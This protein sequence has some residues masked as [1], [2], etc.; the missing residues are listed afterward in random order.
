MPSHTDKAY[1]FLYA[2]EEGRWRDIVASFSAGD[3]DWEDVQEAGVSRTQST[4]I[5]PSVM[6]F[7]SYKECATF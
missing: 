5:S 2:D 7:L 4:S 3:K 1:S 6:L